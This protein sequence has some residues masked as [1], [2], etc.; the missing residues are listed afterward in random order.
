MS[1]LRAPETRKPTDEQFASRLAYSAIGFRETV[2][3]SL[4]VPIKAFENSVV[5][6]NVVYVHS[7]ADFTPKVKV[8][9]ALLLA[10]QAPTESFVP[11][12]RLKDKSRQ[13]VQE[14]FV[15]DGEAAVHLV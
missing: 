2:M 13:Y 15:G 1:A 6:G 9:Q 10:E 7:A 11:T 3:L 4:I 14:I 5:R 12:D 8:T